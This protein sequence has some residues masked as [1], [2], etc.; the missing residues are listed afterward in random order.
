M[1]QLPTPSRVSVP[2]VGST[3]HTAN[4]VAKYDTVVSTPPGA[5]TV[6]AADPNVTED[7]LYW[8][9]VSVWSPL[10]TAGI[11]MSTVAVLP[12]VS[13]TVTVASAV[14]AS[15]VSGVPPIAPV[16]VSRFNPEGNPVTAY[17]SMP[18]PPDGLISVIGTPT[19]NVRGRGVARRRR[20][21][22]V[23]GESAL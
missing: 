1:T 23:H 16:P 9:P 2:L 8:N 3:V 18:T 20:C 5:V 19:F 13:L 7:A 21:R 11:V 15:A 4:G 17:S 10:A 14:F 22:E 6:G 12:A